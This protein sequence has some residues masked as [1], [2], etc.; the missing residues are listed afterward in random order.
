VP[1]WRWPPFGLRSRCTVE[2][3]LA[4]RCSP[5]SALAVW[6][7]GNGQIPTGSR[8]DGRRGQRPLARPPRHHCAGDPAAGQ[9]RRHQRRTW[10]STPRPI[11]AIPRTRWMYA[12]LATQAWPRRW[13]AWV[14]PA[15]TGNTQASPTV[16]GF[17]LRR[18]PEHLRISL[19][20]RRTGAC[21]R[22]A[23]RS[24]RRVPPNRMV[25][26]GFPQRRYRRPFGNYFSLRRKIEYILNDSPMP[27]S[28]LRSSWPALPIGH[29][30]DLSRRSQDRPTHPRW[31]GRLPFRRYYLHLWVKTLNNNIFFAADGQR[32]WLRDSRR[33][34]TFG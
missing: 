14:F 2:S 18:T 15:R 3:G 6:L 28:L 9:S 24:G 8:P 12:R 31:F 27:L 16:E 32:P 30:A 7:H 5:A 25:I 20:C 29:C 22:R 21:V 19:L 33:W 4:H 1:C 23:V 26:S 34:Q 11:A 17:S 13:P 10:R